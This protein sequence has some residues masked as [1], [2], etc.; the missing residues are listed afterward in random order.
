MDRRELIYKKAIKL[1][2][3]RREMNIGERSLTLT[4]KKKRPVE[5]QK[6]IREVSSK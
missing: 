1:T 4:M 5:V 6:N 3:A 2:K